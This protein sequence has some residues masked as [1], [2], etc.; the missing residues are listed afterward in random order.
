[1]EREMKAKRAIQGSSKE[2]EVT[3]AQSN[4]MANGEQKYLINVKKENEEGLNSLKE[5]H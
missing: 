1:M 4:S 2:S 3:E 5:R